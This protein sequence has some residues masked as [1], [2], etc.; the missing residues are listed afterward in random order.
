MLVYGKDVPEPHFQKEAAETHAGDQPALPV[1]LLLTQSLY[2]TPA[3]EAELPIT[4]GIFKRPLSW[5]TPREGTMG[6]TTLQTAL[7]PITAP[8]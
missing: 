8:S 7:V 6:R 5:S 1:L 3:F 2:V 4:Y